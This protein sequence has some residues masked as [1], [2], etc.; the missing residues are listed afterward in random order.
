MEIRLRSEMPQCPEMP[1][2]GRRG[3]AFPTQGIA[4]R[5]AQRREEAIT[6]QGPE[7][8]EV[9]EEEPEAV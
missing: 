3:G 2:L 7:T 6:V 8:L 9:R 4:R 1:G 5:D